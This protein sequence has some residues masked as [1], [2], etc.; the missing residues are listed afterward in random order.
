MGVPG[1]ALCGCGRVAGYDAYARVH[2][3]TCSVAAHR[4]III[5]ARAMYGYLGRSTH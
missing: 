3:D 4:Y 2:V 1:G 5:R